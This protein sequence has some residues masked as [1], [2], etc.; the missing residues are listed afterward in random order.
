MNELMVAWNVYV[1][2][3]SEFYTTVYD[4]NSEAADLVIICN[5]YYVIVMS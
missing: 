4:E 3:Y 2:L 1:M 5:Y